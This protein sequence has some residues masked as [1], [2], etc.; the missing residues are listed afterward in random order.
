MNIELTNDNERKCSF[1]IRENI[2]R[3]T[4]IYLEEVQVLDGFEFWPN[5]PIDIEK[6]ASVSKDHEFIY[7]IPAA[8]KN[9]NDHEYVIHYKE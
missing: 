2:T 8:I 1:I 7:R 9:R 3:D 5:K 4:Y 6:P